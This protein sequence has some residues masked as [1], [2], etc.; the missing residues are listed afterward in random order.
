MNTKNLRRFLLFIG[1]Y[2]FACRGHVHSQQDEALQQFDSAGVE[3]AYAVDGE[4]EPVVVMH[5]MTGNSSNS[6]ELRAALCEADFRVIAFD[7][8]GHG[9]SGKP[10]E[11]AA[12]GTVMVEDVIRLL[13]HLQIEKAHVI[14]YS[15][16]A[17]VANKLREQHPDRLLSVTLGGIGMGV[18]E[19]WVPGEFDH[20]KLA[21]S[22]ETG[23]GMKV[24][25]REPGAV[26]PGRA[27]EAQVEQLN[28]L[29]MAGQDALALAAVIRGYTNLEVSPEKLQT[30]SVPTLLIV[31]EH[32]AE[33]PSAR[34]MEKVTDNLQLIVVPETNH[35][36][37]MNHPD[38]ISAIVQFTGNANR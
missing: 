25:L 32:D 8:R 21:E 29:L 23:E 10:H 38:F 17:D 27:T 18:T 34:E 5:G 26:I 35:L 30:N 3:I 2:W 15:M 28:N 31:G 9:A 4:G 36:T 11:P 20:I 14:G 1:V 6:P 12:Y 19:G 22:L 16:G 37:V 7:A 24:L 33:T 13:D